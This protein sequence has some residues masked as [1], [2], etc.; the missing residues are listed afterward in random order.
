MGW[1]N[2][3]M[4]TEANKV[5]LHLSWQ[6][7]LKVIELRS[8]QSNREMLLEPWTDLFPINGYTL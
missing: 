3:G 8:P 6:W 4:R 1:G 7:L 5:K 2:S